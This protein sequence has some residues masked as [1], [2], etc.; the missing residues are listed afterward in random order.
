MSDFTSTTLPEDHK[1]LIRLM[2]KQ[3][4]QQIGDVEGLFAQVKDKITTEIARARAEEAENG[5]AWPVINWTD[6]A[7]KRITAEQIAA[8]KRRG[9]VVV[10]QT[11]PRDKTLAWDTSMLDYL[12]RN[13]FDAQYCGP[14]ATVVG[15]LDAPRP[16]TYPIHCSTAHMEARPSEALAETPSFPHRLWHG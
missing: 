13:D 1:A 2:K 6:I 9:C 10:K 8:I 4:R 15:S 14:G 5:T 12:D 16:E 7:E 3:L 11:F